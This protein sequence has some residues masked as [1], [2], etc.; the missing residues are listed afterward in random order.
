MKGTHPLELINDVIDLVVEGGIIK[1]L[2]K[3]AFDNKVQ[4]LNLISLL[5]LTPNYNHYQTFAH[6][7]ISPVYGKCVGTCLFYDC[8]FVK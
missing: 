6:A 8:N 7:F 4:S 2:Q 1:H 3:R 5:S